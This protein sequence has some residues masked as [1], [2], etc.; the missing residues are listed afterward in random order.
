[1]SCCFCKSEGSVI[2][3]ASLVFIT[4]RQLPR[5]AASF[6]TARLTSAHIFPFTRI[7]SKSL[8]QA[9]MVLQCSIVLHLHQQHTSPSLLSTPPPKCG[10]ELPATISPAR[11]C[12]YS[13]APG[14]SIIIWSN[15]TQHCPAHIFPPAASPLPPSSPTLSLVGFVL[16]DL[17]SGVFQHHICCILFIKICTKGG[18]E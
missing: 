13:T 8:D 17:V 6:S 3:A 12:Y 18:Q 4:H 1:M 15:Q 5:T 10:L 2:F 11:P 7:P 9:L 14:S 16:I